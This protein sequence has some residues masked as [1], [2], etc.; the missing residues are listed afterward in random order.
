MTRADGRR[1]ACL[2]C[3]TQIDSALLAI[4]LDDHD[5]P[6][7]RAECRAFLTGESGRNRWFDKHQLVRGTVLAALPAFL[8]AC[9]PACR[10]LLPARAGV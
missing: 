4:A 6:D 7:L 9:L 8:P 10:V 2:P 1:G 3:G 5:V